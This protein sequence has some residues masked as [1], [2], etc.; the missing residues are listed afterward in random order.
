MQPFE[1]EPAHWLYGEVTRPILNGNTSGPSDLNTPEAP[2]TE[3][4]DSPASPE[5]CPGPSRAPDQ[6][7]RHEETAGGGSEPPAAPQMNAVDFN[8]YQPLTDVASDVVSVHVEVGN[9]YRYKASVSKGPLNCVPT[10]F[11]STPQT[12]VRMVILAQEFLCRRFAR[13]P[14]LAALTTV[15]A[16]ARYVGPKTYTTKEVLHTLQALLRSM[17]RAYSKPFNR[18]CLKAVPLFFVQLANHAHLE[19]MWT[20]RTMKCNTVEAYI[21]VTD[22]CPLPR[23]MP[24]VAVFAPITEDI[25]HL[26]WPW[27]VKINA[28]FLSAAELSEDTAPC[29]KK[30]TQKEGGDIEVIDLTDSDA[31]ASTSTQS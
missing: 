19:I 13:C 7:N 29:C 25:L 16:A 6:P 17:P 2:T 15:S 12:T 3:P 14:T 24:A 28:E 18:H 22:Q 26:S 31:E 8:R 9:F 27:T 10:Q 21:A 30:M 5:P 4:T 1:V 20:P 11:T 23:L